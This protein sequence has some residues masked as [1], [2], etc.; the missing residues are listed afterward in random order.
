MIWIPPLCFLAGMVA[1]L[2]GVLLLAAWYDRRKS[3]V[4]QLDLERAQRRHPSNVTVLHQ[5]T[6]G[7]NVR[8][9]PQRRW[10]A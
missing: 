7:S 9:L 10:G 5:R 1:G 2:P 3:N 6:A 4:V 8:E